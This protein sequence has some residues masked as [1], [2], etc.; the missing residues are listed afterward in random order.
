MLGVAE[1]VSNII[2]IRIN[3]LYY[4]CCCILLLFCSMRRGHKNKNSNNSSFDP[5]SKSNGV[6][7]FAPTPPQ[8]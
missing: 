8:G 7:V 2:I 6:R 4:A 3:I 5:N 1:L